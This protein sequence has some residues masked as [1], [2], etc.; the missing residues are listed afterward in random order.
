MTK[1]RELCLSMRNIVAEIEGYS[2][3][4]AR[5]GELPLFTIF[6]LFILVFDRLNQ[7]NDILVL[8]AYTTNYSYAQVSFS[9]LQEFFCL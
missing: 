4:R 5:Y 2:T 6:H 1:L 7:L 8:W 9:N 3:S